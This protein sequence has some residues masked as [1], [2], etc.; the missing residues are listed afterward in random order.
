MASAMHFPVALVLFLSSF[1]L[2]A[3]N[4]APPKKDVETATVKIPT[5]TVIGNV[6]NGVESFGGIPFAQAPVGNLRL[7]PPQR[8]TK[9]I[10]VFDA[11]GP[12]G[13]C[14]QQVGSIQGT[15]FV[16]DLIGNI[17]NLPFIQEA[18]GQ[19]EDCLTITVARPQGLSPDAKLPVLFWIFGGGFQVRLASE[20]FI[21]V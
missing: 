7:R 8:L 13:A 20:I 19:G 2:G 21:H 10:G 5:A 1:V 4:P 16:N 6:K 11:T 9:N 12:A 18:T 14:P 15:N 17:A 3:P